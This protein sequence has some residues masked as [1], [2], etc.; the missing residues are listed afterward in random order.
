MKKQT[1]QLAVVKPKYAMPSL[2]ELYDDKIEIVKQ[3]KLNIILNAEPKIDWIKSHPFVSGLK[4]LP[5]ERVEYLLTMIFSR[6]NVEIKSVQHVANSVVVTVRLFVQNPITG[7]MDFQDGVGAAP[8]QVDKG[9]GA[10]DFN[11]IKSSAIQISAPAAESYAIKD[12][13]EKLGRIFGKDLNRKDTIAYADRLHASIEIATKMSI[14]EEFEK[15]ESKEAVRKLWLE[16]NQKERDDKDIKVAYELALQK[17]NV[18][19]S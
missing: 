1:K 2:Q 17:Y 6:W 16:L 19:K 18:K 13:A 3:N 5:I 11:K 10:I 12:A 8:M 9:A 15:T 7:E 4:Y 14:I